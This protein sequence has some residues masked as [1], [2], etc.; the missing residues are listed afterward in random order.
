MRADDIPGVRFYVGDQWARSESAAVSAGDLMGLPVY[1][2]IP[3]DPLLGGKF[4]YVDGGWEWIGKCPHRPDPADPENT[5]APACEPA[6]RWMQRFDGYTRQR[7]ALRAEVAH[8][9]QSE[10]CGWNLLPGKIGG[11]PLDYA[12]CTSTTIA[13]VG[14][15]AA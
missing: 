10:R 6:C 12:P 13:R 7:N 5:G 15:G 8:L 9:V 4:E 11:H 2:E 1:M 14:G 3:G